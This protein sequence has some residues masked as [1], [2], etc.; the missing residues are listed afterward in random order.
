M[1]ADE[2]ADA[3]WLI[4]QRK[5]KPTL[6][7]VRPLVDAYYKLEGNLAGGELH[8]V[9]DDCNYERSSIRYCI[10]AAT[11]RESR[12]LGWVLIMLSNSQRRRL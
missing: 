11:K 4:V 7:E 6:P 12:L 9:L 3:C 5:T 1:T 10:S 2:I 8:S